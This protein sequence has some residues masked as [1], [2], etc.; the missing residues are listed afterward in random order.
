MTTTPRQDRSVAVVTGGS[1]GI[2]LG[3]AMALGRDGWQVVI[4]S[5]RAET[6]REAER[7]LANE[8]ISAEWIEA[9]VGDPDSISALAAAA[10]SR[11]R[12][13]VWV[14]NAG[15]AMIKPSLDVTVEEW[16][17]MHAVNVRGV[18]LGACAAARFMR[19]EGH[20]GVIVN[21]GSVAGQIGMPG[22][23]AY[24]ASKHAVEGITK[25]L[26]IEWGPSSIRVVGVDPGYIMTEMVRRG[27]ERAGFALDDVT[28]RIPLGR[29][30]EPSEIGDVVAQV[31]RPE[32]S[33]L[34]GATVR[35]DGGFV[36]HGGFEDLP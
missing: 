31:C 30:G 9:D 25:V 20:G 8:G 2:G 14:N 10:A 24:C 28:R 11:G 27:Q 15:V 13:G 1:D 16:D 6:G 32:A 5:R 7:K 23:A 17:S 12:L 3:A 22:R 29:L 35:V 36:A 18:F 33:Y 26:A 4:A 34:T 21:V 19:D